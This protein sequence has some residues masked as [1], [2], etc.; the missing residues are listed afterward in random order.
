MKMPSELLLLAK[1]PL[2]GPALSRFI[3]DVKAMEAY[4][5]QN[6][7]DAARYRYL[8]SDDGKAYQGDPSFYPYAVLLPEP[9]TSDAVSPLFGAELDAAVDRAMGTPMTWDGMPDHAA[10]LQVSACEEERADCT[11]QTASSKPCPIHGVP[12]VEPS[13][14]RPPNQLPTTLKGE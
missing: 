5:E 4:A 6:A 12:K 10:A 8:R 1:D 14:E 11:C 7:K 2:M 9:K 3:E 13:G